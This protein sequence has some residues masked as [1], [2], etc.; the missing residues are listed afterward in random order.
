M[1]GFTTCLLH[2]LGVSKYIQNDIRI[3]THGISCYALS[4]KCFC[5]F[6]RLL[7]ENHNVIDLRRQGRNQKHP[8]YG[9]ALFKEEANHERF[10]SIER[11][12][13]IHF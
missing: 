1:T 5:L 10:C 12:W 11:L 6:A 13:Y 9:K 3:D 4:M 8:I 2:A 7:N